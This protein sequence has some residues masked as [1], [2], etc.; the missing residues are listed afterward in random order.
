MPRARGG[1]AR[2]PLAWLRGSPRSRKGA[3]DGAGDP[4]ADYYE[5]L[6]EGTMRDLEETI[7]AAGALTLLSGE[8]LRR[9]EARLRGLEEILLKGATIPLEGV[10]A[11]GARVPP[12]TPEVLLQARVGVTCDESGSERCYVGDGRPGRVDEES[13]ESSPVGTTPEKISRESSLGNLDFLPVGPNGR[14]I[15]RLEAAEAQWS[16]PRLPLLQVK[17]GRSLNDLTAISA[18][19]PGGGGDAAGR[20]CANVS[21][22]AIPGH[23]ADRPRSM[24]SFAQVEFLNPEADGGLSRLEASVSGWAPALKRSRSVGDMRQAQAV[25]PQ[26]P[27]D[28]LC[29]LETKRSTWRAPPIARPGGDAGGGLART[30][31]LGDL[32]ELAAVRPQG[33]AGGLNRLQTRVSA[34]TTT[35]LSARS[36]EDG[37]PTA[38][39]SVAPRGLTEQSGL[40]R[41]EASMWQWRQCAGRGGRP[42]ELR[43]RK[44]LSLGD[45]APPRYGGNPG[46]RIPPGSP[47]WASCS[48]FDSE[49]AH[50]PRG[51]P[52]SP[53]QGDSAHGQWRRWS[54]KAGDE[55]SGDEGG[56]RFGDGSSTQ[57]SL[58]PSERSVLLSGRELRTSVEA[59]GAAYNEDGVTRLVA[60]G[61]EASFV[62]M[63]EQ[64]LD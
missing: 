39:S 63:E 33:L 5:D 48:D 7:M 35:R 12:P 32:R 41:L 57:R 4:W 49:T 58:A 31:S 55:C 28:G 60:D 61:P 26:D 45:P 47:M 22:W 27:A 34:W 1:G 15:D 37:G 52:L 25:A 20:L 54:R 21:P 43:T 17:R 2:S 59:G 23:M 30:R 42:G 10:R 3:G 9:Y 38:V 44:L 24:G 16:Y 51:E 64:G 8:R 6:D 18:V 14:G 11:R 53:F 40:S 19:R 62:V 36:E 13:E 50:T 46:G 29:I 56:S